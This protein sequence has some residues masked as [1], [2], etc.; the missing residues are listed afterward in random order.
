MT[1]ASNSRLSGSVTVSSL[2]P[3]TTWLLVTMYPSGDTIT[4][5]PMPP[6][7]GS[8]GSNQ[9]S[10]G[11]CGLLGNRKKSSIRSRNSRASR[12]RA[13]HDPVIFTSAGV[14]A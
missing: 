9:G 3:C 8:R 7:R 2:A 13:P 5:E 6:P 10:I 11:P 12:G 4:P 1:F 14:T